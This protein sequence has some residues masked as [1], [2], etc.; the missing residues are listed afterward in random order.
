[1]IKK[2]LQRNTGSCRDTTRDQDGFTLLLAV[3]IAGILLAIGLAIFNITIKGLLL[4]SSG[5]DSQFAFYAADTGAECA[6]YWDQKQDSFATSSTASISC[7]R[8]SIVDVGGLGYDVPSIFQFEVDGFC[9]IV[10]VT[11]KE[12]HPRTKIESKGYNTSCGN[13]ENPRRIERAIRV[14]Y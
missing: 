13:T 3:L 7:N 9:T 10:S 11:K 2:I 6:L 14:T 4:S 5:R 1:M 8:A 12:T